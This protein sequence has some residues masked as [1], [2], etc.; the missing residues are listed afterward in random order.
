MNSRPIF[1]LAAKVKAWRERR[2]AAELKRAAALMSA[3]AREKAAVPIRM[4]ADQLK[5]EL[6]LG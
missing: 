6:G 3:Y 4:K 1:N 5:R 2:A